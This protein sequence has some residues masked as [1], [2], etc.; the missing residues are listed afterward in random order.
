[1]ETREIDDLVEIYTE[2]WRRGLKTTYYLHTKPR[3]SAEQSTTTV[4]KSQGTNKS[5]FANALKQQ[6]VETPNQDAFAVSAPPAEPLFSGAVI[7]IETSSV[8][9]NEVNKEEIDQLV[10]IEKAKVLSV[11]NMQDCP[12]D[13]AE[14]FLCEACQ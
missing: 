9:N 12:V 10:V 13:P 14:R 5:G 7:T 8:V 6:V 3:H 1:L 11:M 4:N 2:A